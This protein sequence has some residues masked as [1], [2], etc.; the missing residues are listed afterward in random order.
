MNALEK[1]DEMEFQRKEATNDTHE[2]KNEGMDS[3][4]HTNTHTHTHT[5]IHTLAD[6]VRIWSLCL[7]FLHF[8]FSFF[9]SRSII[10]LFSLSL[11]SARKHWEVS[12][13][14]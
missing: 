6:G 5:P 9:S 2:S 10:P 8:A 14:R 13:A 4:E 7:V 1:Q 11:S 12:H 3:P